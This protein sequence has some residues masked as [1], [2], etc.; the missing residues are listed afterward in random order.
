VNPA[1]LNSEVS[2]AQHTGSQLQSQYNKQASQQYS[3]YQNTQKQANSAYSNLSNYN[4]GMADPQQLYN[5]AVSQA[6]AA[7]GFDPHTLATATQNLTQSQ[8]ALGAL[9]TAA[10]QGVNG[11]GLTGAQLA[12]RYASMT[13]PLQGVVS[14]QNNA[15]GNLQQL[16][17]NSLTQGQQSASLG[18]QGEQLKSQN[19]QSLYQ[20]AVGQ[21]Q[22]TGQT[23][24]EIENLQQQQGYL[25]A[26]QV[27]A[28][29]NAYSGYVSAQAA[30]QQASAA[31]VQAQAQS[32]LNNQ[33]AAQVAQQIALAKQ[34]SD[35]QKKASA[36]ALSLGAG[37]GYG[38]LG[39]GNAS[40]GRL[41]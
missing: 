26:Q 21:M 20:N 18:F 1:Q 25:T 8:N 37:N 27:S 13:Q 2:S 12:G 28:Y 15:V 4:K 14:A 33:Q 6:Q 24:K 32:H 39:I 38:Q 10:Q 35:Q 5:Q 16:Y 23:L 11:Y 9:N 30:Q 7:Q 40:G 17:Q 3:A 22:T 41:Q 34:V 19:Y 36:P 31:M 29:Q